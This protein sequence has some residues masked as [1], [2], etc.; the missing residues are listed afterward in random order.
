MSSGILSEIPLASFNE[1]PTQGGPEAPQSLEHSSGVGKNNCRLLGI[2]G[3]PQARRRVCSFLVDLIG[4]RPPKDKQ[5]ALEAV[6]GNAGTAA[7]ED[8]VSTSA[9]DVEA[10]EIVS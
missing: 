2:L 3:S 8:C 4:D 9:A 10:K 7:I 5:Q 1:L 6:A